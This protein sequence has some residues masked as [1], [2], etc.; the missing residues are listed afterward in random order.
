MAT[1]LDIDPRL[2]EKALRLGGHRTKKAVVKEALEEYVQRREQKK[3]VALF[4][5]IEFDPKYDYKVQRARK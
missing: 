4:D 1:N 2:I 3:I 5:K